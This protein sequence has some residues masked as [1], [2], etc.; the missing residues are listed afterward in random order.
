MEVTKRDSGFPCRSKHLLLLVASVKGPATQA[1]PTPA[2]QLCVAPQPWP[3]V[4]QA[5][6]HSVRPHTITPHTPCLGPHNPRL[7]PRQM[8]SGPPGPPLCFP[9]SALQTQLLGHLSSCLLELRF[10]Y[11]SSVPS[12]RR[13]SLTPLGA[14]LASSPSGLSPSDRFVFMVPW[15]QELPKR[16]KFHSLPDTWGLVWCPV[17]MPM[18]MDR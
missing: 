10:P 9:G 12:F 17:G 18:G 1:C 11:S 3:G 4:T 5:Q 13:P 15:H 8:N 6:V 14:D 2:P 16:Q 7:Q